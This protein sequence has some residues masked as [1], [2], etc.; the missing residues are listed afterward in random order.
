MYTEQ[1]PY[2]EIG[3]VALMQFLVANPVFAWITILTQEAIDLTNF[4]TCIRVIFFDS[5]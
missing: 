4:F 5:S 3:E 1:V 2:F